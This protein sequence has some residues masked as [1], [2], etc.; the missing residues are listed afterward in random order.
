MAM[1]EGHEG[2]LGKRVVVEEDAHSDLER[3]GSGGGVRAVRRARGGKEAGA[4]EEAR[5]RHGSGSCAR[6]QGEQSSAGEK[7]CVLVVHGRR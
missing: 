1:I 4:G 2:S 7:V 6:S 5:G 3:Q